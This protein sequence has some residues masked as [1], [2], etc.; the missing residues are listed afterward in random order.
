MT[1]WTAKRTDGAATAV[2]V[3][4]EAGRVAAELGG[5]PVVIVTHGRYG[6]ELVAAAEA[7]VG[8]LGVKVVSVDRPADPCDI[9]GWLE[10]ALG[11]GWRERGALLLTD[12][13]G[14]TPHR[15]CMGLARCC[16]GMELVSGLNLA[17]L[18]KL[19]TVDRRHA[20]VE[21]AEAL[22]GTARR[23]VQVGSPPPTSTR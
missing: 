9:R 4:R 2:G 22:V 5:T 14:G 23:S 16:P 11:P 10:H 18:L 3:A 7:I 1:A 8:P 17:M 15:V 20:A 6:R 12:I 13:Y 19:A 21:I